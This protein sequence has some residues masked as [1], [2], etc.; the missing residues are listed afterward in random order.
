M[1]EKTPGNGIYVSRLLVFLDGAN[2]NFQW[3]RKYAKIMKLAV[4]CAADRYARACNYIFWNNSAHTR[5]IHRLAKNGVNP[6]SRRGH[7]YAGCARVSTHIFE[8]KFL[9]KIIQGY[10]SQFNYAPFP[11]LR[12]SFSSENREML[13]N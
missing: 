13:R 4:P 8:T 12:C 7:W 3:R 5:N 11:F 2:D 6:H 9:L 1:N 10:I